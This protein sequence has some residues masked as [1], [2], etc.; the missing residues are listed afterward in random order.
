MSPYMVNVR[1]FAEA[2]NE[3]RDLPEDARRRI[4]I[5][6]ERLE[7]PHLIRYLYNEASS[8]PSPA[9]PLSDIYIIIGP[10]GGFTAEEIDLALSI[11][12]APCSL[13][14]TILRAE[15]AAIFAASLVSSFG[16]I[17]C[18]AKGYHLG[19]TNHIQ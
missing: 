4:F 3:L 8:E 2:L 9:V 12:C 15:T 11:G 17:L 16:E 7:A 5:C 18:A 6:T 19:T 10:E 13:G 1:T 14:P